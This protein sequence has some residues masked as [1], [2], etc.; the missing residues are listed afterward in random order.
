MKRLIDILISAVIAAVLVV[1]ILFML[2][3]AMNAPLTTMK[4]TSARPTA[5]WR[6]A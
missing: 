4:P 5:C 1:L 6:A 3:D 2:A